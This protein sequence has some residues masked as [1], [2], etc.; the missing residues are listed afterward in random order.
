M[1]TIGTI[2]KWSYDS[3]MEEMAFQDICMD[4][5]MKLGIP[6]EVSITCG[7]EKGRKY[8]DFTIK[9]GKTNK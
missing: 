2:R 1:D 9:Q 7:E 4:K 3:A 6:Y 8:W 5:A